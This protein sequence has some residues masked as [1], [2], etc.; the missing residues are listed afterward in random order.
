VSSGSNTT[1]PDEGSHQFS[2]LVGRT[3]AGVK[4]VRLK[5]EDGARVTASTANGWFLA[6]WPGRHF[7][8]ALEVTTSTGTRVQPFGDKSVQVKSNAG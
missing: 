8:T 7:V 3:G 2:R 5:F 4:A 6:W 1:P